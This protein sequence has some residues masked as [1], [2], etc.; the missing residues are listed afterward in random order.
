MRYALVSEV[1]TEASPRARGVCLNPKCRGE[2]IAR[3]GRV[4]VWHWAHKGRPPCDPWHE[5]ET[6]WHRDWKDN[7]PVE[8]QEVAHTDPATA[9]VHIADVKTPHGLTI[10]FQHSP[11]PPAEM[12]SR[13]AFYG[14]M[15]WIVDGRRGELDASF[16]RMGLHG[17][18]QKDPLAYQV[19]WLG[20][21]QLLRNWGEAGA[22]VYLDF[23]GE[24]LW[25][26]VFYD[27][28]EKRGAVGPTYRDELVKDCLAGR[29]IHVTRKS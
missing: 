10:E 21:G 19:D 12:K 4:K 14:E 24:V 15:I 13:E 23:G 22:K 28:I 7:F 25:R 9:E 26:L 27:P 1:K 8:W 5:S 2:M 16:F 3:C 20:R 17:P 11:I 6:K 18:I 29:Q